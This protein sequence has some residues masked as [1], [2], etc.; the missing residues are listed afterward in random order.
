MKCTLRN[1]TYTVTL[2]DFP[3][4]AGGLRAAGDSAYA[5]LLLFELEHAVYKL[6]V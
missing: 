5:I 6:Q 4:S 1:Q 3:L 2:T